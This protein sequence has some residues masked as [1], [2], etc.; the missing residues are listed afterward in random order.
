V[1]DYLSAVFKRHEDA[2]EAA[3]ATLDR[4]IDAAR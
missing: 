3:L 1:F 2:E 4:E